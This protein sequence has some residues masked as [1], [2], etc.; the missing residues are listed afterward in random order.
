MSHFVSVKKFCDLLSSGY[1]KTDIKCYFCAEPVCVEY[2][3]RVGGHESKLMVC[4]IC[5]YDIK[6][7]TS[8]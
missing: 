7:G 8:S 3:F 6:R 2:K 4:R 1:T 5:D